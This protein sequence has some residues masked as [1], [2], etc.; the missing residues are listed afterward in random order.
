MIPRYA[1]DPLRLPWI[2]RPGDMDEIAGAAELL[3][4]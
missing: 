2:P 4:A 3:R 1:D